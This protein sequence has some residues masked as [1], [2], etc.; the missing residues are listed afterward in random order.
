MPPGHQP[1]SARETSPRMTAFES[2]ADSSRAASCL[3]KR[4]NLSAAE[5]VKPSDV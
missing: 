3:K 2:V 4:R 1:W 5:P